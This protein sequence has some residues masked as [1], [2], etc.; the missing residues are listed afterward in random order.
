LKK[1]VAGKKEAS[2]EDIKMHAAAIVARV[3]KI[4]QFLFGLK[5]TF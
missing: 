5:L 4:Q 1:T 3:K 2:R